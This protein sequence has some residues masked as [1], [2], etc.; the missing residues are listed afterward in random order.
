MAQTYVKQLVFSWLRMV[1]R[2][3]IFGNTPW[4]IWSYKQTPCK[5]KS[6]KIPML[7]LLQDFLFL[8]PKFLLHIEA[9]AI[10]GGELVVA[11]NRGFGIFLLQLLYQG[12][13][14]SLLLGCAGV[15]RLAILG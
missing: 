6:F 7:L 3:V 2:K 13:Q 10:L 4:V 8:L 9:R 5:G 15:L 12:F 14:R 11:M 1:H